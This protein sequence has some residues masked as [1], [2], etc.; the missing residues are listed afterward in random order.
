MDEQQLQEQIQALV[1]AAM[2]GDEQAIQQI[3][4][5]MQAAE[6]GDQQAQQIAMLIQE[7]IQ[8][9]QG[10]QGGVGY[11]KKGAKLGYINYLRGK[12]PDGYEIGYYEKGGNLCKACVKKK[13]RKC[14][15]G[16]PI[17]TPNNAVE[18]FKCG[19]QVK[20][21]KAS[22][23]SKIENHS[24]GGKQQGLNGTP[25]TRKKYSEYDYE[26]TKRDSKGRT[27]VRYTTEDGT[28]YKGRN[29]KTDMEATQVGDS[30]RRA[31]WLRG[32]RIRSKKPVKKAN[33]GSFVP[34]MN[35]VLG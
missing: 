24:G 12:C 29:G 17:P 28:L 11:A 22:C 27:S 23:G 18:A 6:Q 25:Y 5:I 1:T 30:I 21:K 15:N 31:D 10:G 14:Q 3:Q 33:G 2:N 26:D 20:K 8:N 4:Q 7:E 35:R 9:A 13:K 16:Q 19:R 32:E 34:F